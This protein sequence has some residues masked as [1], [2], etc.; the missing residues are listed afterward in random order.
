MTDEQGRAGRARNGCAQKFDQRIA[1]DLG[2]DSSKGPWRKTDTRSS[3]LLHRCRVKAPVGTARP[4]GPRTETTWVRPR[5]PTREMTPAGLEKIS[6]VH[7]LEARPPD[8]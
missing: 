2:E 4:L 3:Q 8:G 7:H 6:R 5:F 1:A